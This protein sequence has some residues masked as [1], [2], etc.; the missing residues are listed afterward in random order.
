VE[1]IGRKKEKWQ[2]GNK[3]GGRK[4]KGKKF[5]LQVHFK[6]SAVGYC[7]NYLPPVSITTVVRV[8]KFAPGVVYTI[9]QMKGR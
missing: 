7:Y 9:L 3:L 5:S 6:V 2:A 4:K 1:K 8:A